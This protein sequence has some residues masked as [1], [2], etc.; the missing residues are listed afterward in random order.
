MGVEMSDDVDWFD[1]LMSNSPKQGEYW[2]PGTTCSRT[3]P[4]VLLLSKDDQMFKAPWEDRR[5][6]RESG[7]QV[8]VIHNG[9]RLFLPTRLLGYRANAMEV[10]AWASR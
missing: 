5:E 1:L 2:K 8:E 4:V 3:G 10:I 9:K 6:E 7:W